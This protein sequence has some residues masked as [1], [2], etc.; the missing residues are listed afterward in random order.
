MTLLPQKTRLVI[1]GRDVVIQAW[2]YYVTNP[3]T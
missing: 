1:E 3:I 2:V